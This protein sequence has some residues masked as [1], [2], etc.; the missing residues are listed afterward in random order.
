MLP[1][2]V[3]ARPNI[4]ATDQT[5]SAEWGITIDLL[6]VTGANCMLLYIKVIAIFKTIGFYSQKST[7]VGHTV[8]YRTLR[9]LRKVIMQREPLCPVVLRVPTALQVCF[10]RADA[11]GAVESLPVAAIASVDQSLDNPRQLGRLSDSSP[12]ACVAGIKMR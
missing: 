9:E 2:Q 4:L 10:S 7:L 1:I 8:I 11:G 5:T 6:V 12:I 3:A